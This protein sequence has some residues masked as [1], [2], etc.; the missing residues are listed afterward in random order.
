MCSA[1][2]AVQ[3]DAVAIGSLLN[4]ELGMVMTARKQ[5]TAGQGVEPG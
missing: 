5:P 3:P 4:E 2:I 1:V